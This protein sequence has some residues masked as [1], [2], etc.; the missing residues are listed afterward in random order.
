MLTKPP[1][2]STVAAQRDPLTEALEKQVESRLRERGL[3]IWLDKDGAYTEF[4]DELARRHQSGQFFAPVVAY[5][6]SFLDTMFALEPYQDG[7][8]PEPLLLHVPGHTDQTIKET[9][10]LEAYKAGVRFDRALETLVREV[11]AGKAAP[12]ATESFLQRTDLSL[13]AAQDWLAQQGGEQSGLASYLRNLKPEWVTDSLV[14][15]DRQFLSH[16]SDQTDLC[17]LRDYLSRHTGFSSE[18]EQFFHNARSSGT[19]FELSEA[20]LGWVLCVEYVHDLTRPPVLEV[21]KPLRQLS[22]P[23]LK[24]CRKLCEHLRKHHSDAYREAANQ[25]ES[26]LD[27]ELKAGEPDELGKIDTFSRED[28]RLLEAAV[29][30]L[31]NDQWSLA[32][33]WASS[34]LDSPSVWLTHDQLRR[35]EWMLVK[36]AAH[37][38]QAILSHAKP[39]RKVGSLAEAME[40]YTGGGKGARTDGAQSVDRAHRLF[41]QD[42]ARLLTSKL[43]HFAK[44]QRAAGRLRS[45]YRRW[46]DDLNRDFAELC[47][48]HGYLPDAHL[49]QRTLYE[50]EVHPRTQ[51]QSNVAFLMVDALRY[52]MACELANSLTEKDSNIH[53]KSRLAELPS[54]TSVGMNVLAPVCQEGKLT[55][56]GPFK[57]FRVG[58]YTVSTN[59]ARLRAMGERSLD[60]QPKGRKTPVAFKLKELLRE[61]PGKLRSKVKESPLIVVHS[62]E[63]DESGEAD[64]GLSAFDSWIGQLRSAVLHLHAAGVEEFLITADHGFLLLDES[65]PPVAYPAPTVDR[66]WVLTDSYVADDDKSSVSLEALGYKGQTGHLMFLRD[67]GVFQTRGQSARTFVHG[68]NS[69]QER[70]IPVLHISYAKRHTDLNLNQYRITADI[71]PPVMGCSR[72]RVT[73]VKSEAGSGFLEF[74]KGEKITVAFRVPNQAGQVIIKDAP[75][76]ELHNQQLL[77]EEDKPVEVYFTLI[78]SGDDKAAVEI[79]HP[80]GI[81]TVEPCRPAAYFPVEVKKGAPA[82]AALDDSGSWYDN[83]P[84]GVRQVFLHIEKHGSIT[85]AETTGM[86]GNPR[87]ARQ[88]ATN[89][90]AFVKLLP[91]HVRVESTAS[92]KRWVK[93]KG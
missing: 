92:G 83:L 72:L 14:K 22:A 5:R 91:F 86:L 90:E 45:L 58:E 40:N 31:E 9:P 7:L 27:G 10:L 70:V 69:L 19:T 20:F 38:G 4:V 8:D 32:L 74:S 28:S 76:A 57:G 41:E 44:L 49:Q 55:V 82:P 42:H 67:S 16:I 51:T 30:A 33:G 24:T 37:L 17:H 39:L 63:I 62:R 80:D 35:Q 3:V 88:F 11:A 34:R 84:E 78:G 85:E 81:K 15:H 2:M 93:D 43:P 1:T 29:N 89:F 77:L 48:T 26:L 6:G 54:I 21:L 13:K 50:Q 68:G 53:L 46:V 73:L 47:S 18:F 12:E 36:V 61:T 87:K 52:E 56:E 64:V 71:L 60:K 75:E 66:R 25:M 65:A 59:Q 23:L 79:Y